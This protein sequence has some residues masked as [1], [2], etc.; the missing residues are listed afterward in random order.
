MASREEVSGSTG[1]GHLPTA[2][3]GDRSAVLSDTWPSRESHRLFRSGNGSEDY[4]QDQLSP[5]QQKVQKLRERRHHLR[6]RLRLK[7][8]QFSASRR[9]NT[10]ERDA[11]AEHPDGEGVIQRPE[12]EEE[13]TSHLSASPLP[14][15]RPAGRPSPSAGAGRSERRRKSSLLFSSRQDHEARK[16][17]DGEREGIGDAR[18]KGRRAG[19]WGGAA[20]FLWCPSLVKKPPAVGAC[21]A[22]G[23]PGVSSGRGR[24]K[25]LSGVGGLEVKS[26]AD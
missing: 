23:V 10:R 8:S 1:V 25:V 14:G 16:R 15:T 7:R 21:L 20:S 2:L 12:E 24:G 11:S 19:R 13:P 18:R 6:S 26:V 4:G 9:R 3:P 5:F 22:A 17:R